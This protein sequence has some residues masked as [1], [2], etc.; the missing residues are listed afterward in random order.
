MGDPGHAALSYR[1]AARL[2]PRDPDIRANATLVQRLAGAPAPLE[3]RLTFL[4]YFS[5]TEWLWIG[6]AG[7]VSGFL[8]L[9]ILAFARDFRRTGRFLC[10]MCAALVAASAA[11][12]GAWKQVDLDG[13]SVVIERAGV[14]AHFAPLPDAA[15]HFHLPVA[16]IV[17]ELDRKGDWRLVRIE[18]ATGW[19]PARAV[20]P[21]SRPEGREE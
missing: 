6:W 11:G 9:G 3:R 8:L 1:R 14:D 5:A 20:R 18:G 2:K 17:R 4:R 7:Y 12:W 15:V 13:E 19:I 21:V 16:S 10:L